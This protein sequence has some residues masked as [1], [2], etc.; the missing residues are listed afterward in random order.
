M[1]HTTELPRTSSVAMAVACMILGIMLALATPRFKTVYSSLYGDT[2]LPVPTRLVL[3]LKPFGWLAIGFSMAALV[4]IKDLWAPLR[5][6][7]AWPW[8]L[9]LIIAGWLA[10]AGLF[11]PMVITF[12]KVAP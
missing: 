4:V 9:A 2:V 8:V 5:R 7:P 1:A 6:V 11:L 12:T 3:A 10:V